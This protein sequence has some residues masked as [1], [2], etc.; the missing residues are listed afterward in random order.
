M[1]GAVLIDEVGRAVIH[2]EVRDELH[3][4]PGDTLAF[5]TEGDT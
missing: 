4:E 2:K 1:E 3:L 5:A